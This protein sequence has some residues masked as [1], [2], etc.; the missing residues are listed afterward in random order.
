MTLDARPSPYLVK[1]PPAVFI[2]FFFFISYI[3]TTPYIGGDQEHYR[4]F[5]KN[6]E[7]AKFVEISFLQLVSTG[8]AEPLY[9]ILM[10]L[11]SNAGIDKDIY[12]AF[13]NAF[14]CYLVLKFLVKF[15]SGVIFNI[16]MFSNYYLLVLLTSAER[17]KFSYMFLAL[18]AGSPTV[19]RSVM[20]LSISPLFHFQS[21]ILI[22]SK[23]FGKISNIHIS[24]RIKKRTFFIALFVLLITMIAIPLF[25]MAFSDN[26]IRKA[27][28]YS[29]SGGILGITNIVLLM[30]ASY[31]VFSKKS[32]ILIS[33]FV[34]AVFAIFIGPDRVNMIAVSIFLHF[35]IINRKTNN[36][37]VLLLMFY[38]SLKSIGYIGSIFSYGSGFH[39]E[40]L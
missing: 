7:S 34:C 15:N 23:I 10:W 35:V 18:A 3:I 30:V 28:L 36:F 31:F 33:L 1:I 9:G 12:I 38:F 25:F 27:I 8:S 2:P 19:R 37:L 14:F 6:V 26:L 32:E 20:W 17:L 16:F 40:G 4:A 21:L 24:S 5:Y 11:G 29:K 22:F 13:F 39:L